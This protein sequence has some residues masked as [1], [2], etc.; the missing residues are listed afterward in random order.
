LATSPSELDTTDISHKALQALR[1]SKIRKIHV[2][3]RRGPLESAF[4]PKEIRELLA[5][6]NLK[7]NVD[8]SLLD[9]TIS[10]N[11]EYL[12]SN[13]LKRRLMDIL[14]K[15]AKNSPQT[16]EKE[17]CLNYLAS[18]IGFAADNTGSLSSVLFTRNKLE[19][20]APNVTC[21]S[22][23]RIFD[24]PCGL[25]IKSIGYRNSGLDGVPFD[26]KRNMIPNEFGRVLEVL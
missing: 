17:W 10:N 25:V 2:I 22:T 5:T 18:P 13:R 23:G 19:G 24:I 15:G 26:E 14:Q 4:T 6:S 21:K 12:K 20:T 8:K 11:S 1:K 3:G 7:I 9:S 16:A